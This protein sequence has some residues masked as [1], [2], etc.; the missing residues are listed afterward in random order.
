M[1]KKAFIYPGQGSQS[2]GMGISV[3]GAFKEAGGIFKKASELAEYDMLSLCAEGPVEKLSRTLYTQPALYTVEA[4]I[5][6]VLKAHGIE[7]SI[8]AGHSLGE[9]SAWFA[10]GVYSFEDGFMLVSERGR[11]MD[12]ADPDNRGTMAAIIGLDY[13]NVE[14]TCRSV[15][16]T[17]IVANINSPLQMVI[18]GEKDAVAQAGEILKEQGAKRVVQLKVSGAFHS[19]LMESVRDSFA[20]AVEKINIFDA[21]IPVYSNVT[22][23]PVTDAGE[24]RKCMVQQLTSPVR[25]TDTIGNMIS[26]GIKEAFE[27]GP[28]NVLSGLIKRTDDRLAVVSVS[29]SQSVTEVLDEK[30]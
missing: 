25:W 18:S 27:V 20:S 17:V 22:A 9:F 1:K 13:E 24:I 29:D 5:T 12:S 28:G 3:S 6:E 19:P 16:G 26:D 15:D 10:A 30:T 23:S 21:R 11:L 8:C 4:A 2:I 7:P 14:K